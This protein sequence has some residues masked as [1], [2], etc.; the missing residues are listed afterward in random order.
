M[1]SSPN[2]H[3]R[4]ISPEAYTLDLPNTGRRR[5][6][7]VTLKT[8]FSRRLHATPPWSTANIPHG[9]RWEGRGPPALHPGTVF[10]APHRPK[11]L[12]PESPCLA[13]SSRRL[14][15]TSR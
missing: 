9:R 8:V 1:F 11:C 15:R 2:P 5:A 6:S 12:L 7:P 3:R 10:G 4:A 13:P 14:L